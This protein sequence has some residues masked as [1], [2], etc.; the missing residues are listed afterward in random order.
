M[1]LTQAGPVAVESS[2]LARAAYEARESFLQLE[3]R[4][5]AIYRYFDVPADVYDDLLAADSKGSYFNKQIRARFHYLLL[6]GPQ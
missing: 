6:R 1:T 4:D 5:G 3:F 2:L